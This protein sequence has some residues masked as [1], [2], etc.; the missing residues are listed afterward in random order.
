[1]PVYADGTTGVGDPHQSLL[2]PGVPLYSQLDNAGFEFTSC[3]PTALAMALNYQAE[4]PTPQAVVDY[5]RTHMGKN[6]RPLYQPQDPIRVY[7]SPVGLYQV[8]RHYSY[9]LMGWVSDEARAQ[10]KLREL[11]AGG[12]P[13]IVDVT[14][15]ARKGSSRA[16]HFVLVTG[17]D[18]D[19]TVHV[20]D[21]YGRG[22]GAQ[23]LAIPWED[24]YWAWQN[25]SDGSVYGHGWW[26]VVRF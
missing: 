21:P 24:F 5:A 23:R 22:A 26:M 15:A 25:N 13:V 11:L 6:G 18:A 12:L 7:T 2:A 9:P 10:G 8:A 14:V 16:A 17:I 1:M 3:G 20:N 19:N 4:G